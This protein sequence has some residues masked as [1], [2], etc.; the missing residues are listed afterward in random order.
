MAFTRVCWGLLV[1]FLCFSRVY[2]IIILGFTSVFLGFEGLLGF[3]SVFLR[4]TSGF[5]GFA[6]FTRGLLVF[7]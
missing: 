1:F 6:G 5:L 7:F 2:Y 4:F 3:T